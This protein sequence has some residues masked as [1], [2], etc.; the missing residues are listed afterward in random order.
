MVVNHL[1]NFI[2]LED[3]QQATQYNTF[4]ED[5]Y[6]IVDSDALPTIEGM[7][8]LLSMLHKQRIILNGRT[9]V[10]IGVFPTNYENEESQY[11]VLAGKILQADID[12]VIDLGRKCHPA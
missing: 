12:L 11:Q 4:N 1:K 5:I 8:D 2:L 3:H 10:I 6:N 9:I 7:V